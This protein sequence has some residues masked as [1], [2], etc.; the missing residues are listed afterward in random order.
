MGEAKRKRAQS[1]GAI[2]F[3]QFV[4]ERDHAL[5]SM[6]KAILLSYFAKWS[7]KKPPADDRVFWLSVHM[8]RTGV[9]SLPMFERA[10]SKKWLL[11]RNCKSMDDGDVL[12]PLE[13]GELEKY[14]HR[15]EQF[16][17]P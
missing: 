16:G 15:C 7:D 9:M 5:L 8:A 11:T 10:A 3:K 17:C 12:P 1:K 4:A 13:P 6:D 2:D 14:L